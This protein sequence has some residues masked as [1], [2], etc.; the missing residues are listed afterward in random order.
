MT[1]AAHTETA[2]DAQVKAW[3]KTTNLKAAIEKMSDAAAAARAAGLDAIA[4]KIEHAILHDAKPAH[5][6]ARRALYEANNA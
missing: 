5:R 4:R 6:A 2:A 3:T 1:T